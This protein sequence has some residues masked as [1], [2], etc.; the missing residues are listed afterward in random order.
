[1]V[2]IYIGNTR[3]L[4]SGERGS[5]QQNRYGTWS[6]EKHLQVTGNDSSTDLAHT[7]LGL[8][9]I[10]KRMMDYTFILKLFLRTEDTQAHDDILYNQSLSDKS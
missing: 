1:M 6:D 2:I 8:K 10:H 3:N 5:E 9:N 4:I 7:T